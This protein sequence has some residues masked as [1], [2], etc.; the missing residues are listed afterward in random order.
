MFVDDDAAALANRQPAAARQLV[1]GAN[2][3]REHHHVGFQRL[4][5]GELQPMATGLAGHDALGVLAG[6]NRHAEVLDHAAQHR[7]AAIVQ[8]RSHEA[9]GELHHMRLEAHVLERVGPFEAEQAAA[10]HHAHFRRSAGGADRVQVLDGA[11][12]VAMGQVA[13]VDRGHKGRG[14]G[15][16]DER[17]VANPT[18]VTGAYGLGLPVDCRHALADCHRRVRRKGGEREVCRAGAG[19]VVAQVNAI[20]GRARF[21]A[22]YG[23]RRAGHCR[24]KLREAVA[25]HAVAHHDHLSA[26]TRG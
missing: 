11:I 20:V 26:G 6:V 2:A 8:L 19:E 3:G 13:P 21:L 16:E 1:A 12:D 4:A 18:V 15:G 23:N 5:V 7:G 24:G 25:H 10:D 22:E 14:S 17:V 9:G